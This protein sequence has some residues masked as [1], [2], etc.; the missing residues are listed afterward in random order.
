VIDAAS[1]FQRGDDPLLLVDPF[2]RNHGRDVLADGDGG[3]IS[4]QPLR[5]GIAGLDRPVEPLADRVVRGV[6][7]GREEAS[8]LQLTRPFPLQFALRQ[9]GPPDTQATTAPQ[10]TFGRV[11][12]QLSVKADA[13]GVSV[14]VLMLLTCPITA[15]AGGGFLNLF[16]FERPH[17]QRAYNQALTNS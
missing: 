13:A 9:F 4:E 17:T 3:R 2:R 16:P 5:T 12:R 15:Q 14:D 11:S 7:D 8:A 1:G 6:D 10:S